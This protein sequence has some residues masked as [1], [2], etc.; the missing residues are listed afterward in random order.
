V[1]ENASTVTFCLRQSHHEERCPGCG[2]EVGW[3]SCHFAYTTWMCLGCGAHLDSRVVV[4]TTVHVEDGE[5]CILPVFAVTE[6]RP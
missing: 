3:K 4:P 5:P 2:A 6:A 1:S